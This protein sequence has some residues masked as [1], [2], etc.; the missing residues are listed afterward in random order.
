MFC[1]ALAAFVICHIALAFGRV[2]TFFFGT[3]S[4]RPWTNKSVNWNLG[5]ADIT[6]ALVPPVRGTVLKRPISWVALTVLV[7]AMLAVAFGS[8]APTIDKT[9][10]IRPAHLLICGQG[11]HMAALAIPAVR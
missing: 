5:A 10:A 11:A 3:S 7:T 8:Y 9:D 6:G 2:R 4:Q 1:C